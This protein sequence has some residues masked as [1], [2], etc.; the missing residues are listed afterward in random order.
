M[1]F[2]EACFGY[3]PAHADC[4]FA[5]TLGRLTHCFLYASETFLDQDRIN[6]GS[7]AIS[8]SC[9]RQ[10]GMLRQMFEKA[11]G[12]PPNLRVGRNIEA[13]LALR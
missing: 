6:P 2:G 11:P 12:N 3:A 10:H 13:Q 5:K 4:H 8:A 7:I 9:L 1:Y